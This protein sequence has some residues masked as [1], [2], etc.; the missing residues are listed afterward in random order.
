[1]EPPSSRWVFRGAINGLILLDAS[2]HM[3]TLQ[4]HES[5]SVERPC[6]TARRWLPPRP[7]AAPPDRDRLVGRAPGTSAR[8]HASCG[9]AT[10]RP[11]NA[12]PE[13]ETLRSAVQL[14]PN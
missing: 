6:R 10:A 2:H 14:P 4:P 11:A 7:T 12:R 9:R 1:M 8:I 5:C 13:R 3:V